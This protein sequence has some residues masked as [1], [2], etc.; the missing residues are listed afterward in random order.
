MKCISTID[1]IE[2]KY[3]LKLLRKYEHL[4]DG[5]LG[6]FETSDVKLNLKEDAKPYHANT[7]P[8]PKNH[9]DTLKHEIER[10]EKLGVH[11][12]C[13]DSEWAAPTFIIPVKKVFDR[14][15]KSLC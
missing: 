1:D 6:N 12:R 2:K 11:K 9:H 8:V 14:L 7:F 10:L 13:S 4:F 3:L 15:K 5:T